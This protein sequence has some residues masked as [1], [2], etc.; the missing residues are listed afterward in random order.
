MTHSIKGKDPKQALRM[1]RFL[2]AFI[3]YIIWIAIA[4]YCYFNG[5]FVRFLLPVFWIF[6]LILAT[7]L[8]LYCLFRTG[9]N[10]RFKDPSLTMIQMVLATVWTMVMA[11]HL[12]EGRGIMLLLYMVV[13][14]FGAFRLNYRQFILLSILA[15]I[16][17]A[18]VIIL[19]YMY[20]PQHVDLR[21]EIF[22]LMTLFTVLI[23][24]SFVGS[25][26]N[27]LRS[28]L[29]ITNNDLREANINLKNAFNEIRQLK[30]ILP[31]CAS[32][33]KIR[34]DKGYWQQ[35]EEYVRDRTDA[36]FSHSLCP[37]C[38]ELLYPDFIKK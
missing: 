21:L 25:Y 9:L 34:D 13:F 12:D 32:C 16:G 1:K 37:E 23:W 4:L 31:I 33:K 29:G 15:M 2:M 6:T 3:T 19:L 8:I 11:Y 26:I 7:N 14:I 24:F 30:G 5:W 38:S 27:E 35:V 18:A 10:Q 17:Y 22:Y 28:K 20:H 36:E